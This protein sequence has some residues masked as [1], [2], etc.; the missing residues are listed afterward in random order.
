MLTKQSVKKLFV[1]LTQRAKKVALEVA[2]Q[3]D[4]LHFIHQSD[5]YSMHQ[6]HTKLLDGR[7]AL[8]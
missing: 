7:I 8:I 6:S 4:A 2:P 3:S 1:S 5:L